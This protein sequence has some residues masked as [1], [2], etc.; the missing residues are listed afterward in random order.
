MILRNWVWFSPPHPPMAMD[1]SDIVRSR[2]KLIIGEIVYSTVRGASFC[3]VSRIS[4]DDRG[5]PC[6]TSGTQKWNGASPSF[7]VSASVMIMDAVGLNSFMTVHWPEYIKLIITANIRSMEAVA[8]VKKYLVAASVDRGLCCFISIG[9]MASIFISN[10]IQIISQCELV[11]T[12]R[13]P[14]MMVAIM[15]DIIRGFISTGRI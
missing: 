3:H 10:P 7:M 9:I 6:V 8:C 2:F 4:P 5:I 14:R 11:M 13:V 1:A 12:I 15:V